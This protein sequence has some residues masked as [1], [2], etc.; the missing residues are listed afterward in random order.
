MKGGYTL[1]IDELPVGNGASYTRV[2]TY[3]KHPCLGTKSNVTMVL[4]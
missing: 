4:P 3:S 1:L 2:I